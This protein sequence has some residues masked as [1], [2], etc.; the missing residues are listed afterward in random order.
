MQWCYGTNG[1][2]RPRGEA[3][4]QKK[5]CYGTRS[6]PYKPGVYGADSM[7]QDQKPVSAKLAFGGPPEGQ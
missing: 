4:G 1:G 6:K 5:K 7:I 3:R 2:R